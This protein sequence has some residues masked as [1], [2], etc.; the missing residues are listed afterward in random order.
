MGRAVRAGVRLWKG[1]YGSWPSPLQEGRNWGCGVRLD[2]LEMHGVHSQPPPPPGNSP[3]L[4]LSLGNGVALERV[5]IWA[6][7]FSS[8]SQL[9]GPKQVRSPL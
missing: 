9:R 7:P 1:R 8:S 3:L 4:S 2:T 6:P 5:H